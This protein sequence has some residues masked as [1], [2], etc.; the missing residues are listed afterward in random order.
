VTGYWIYGE[1]L[2]GDDCTRGAFDEGKPAPSSEPLSTAVGMKAVSQTI[3]LQSSRASMTVVAFDSVGNQSAQSNPVCVKG[4][5][6]S[7]PGSAEGG[8]CSASPH[9]WSRGDWLVG[10]LG[11]ALVSMMV[12]R[13][14]H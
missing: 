4:G 7:A 9:S 5:M 13:S 8:G 1:A 14:R 6:I 10:L 12:R 3:T 11:S 2:Q